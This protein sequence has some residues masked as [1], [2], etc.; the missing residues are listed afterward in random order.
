[1]LKAHNGRMMEYNYHDK[2]MLPDL[3]RQAVLD[4]VRRAD[5]YMQKNEVAERNVA[6]DFYYNR[7]IDV[8]LQQWFPGTTLNQVPP[9]G[10]R[11]VPRFAKSRMMVLKNI[12]RFV[13]GENAEEYL[14]FTHQLDS[15]A[16]EFSE[17]A[18]LLGRC[19][20]RSKW[21]DRK[22]RIEYDIIPH[23]KEY[24]DPDGYTF[25][26]SYEIHKDHKGKRQFVFWSETRE[27][28][29]GMHFIFNT[30]SEIKPVYGR[31]DIENPYGI[32]PVSKVEFPSNSMDIARGGLQISIAYTELA[33]AIRFALGQPVVTGI[34][35][36]IPNLKAGID[37]LISL[38]E[39]DFKYVS[40]TGSIRDMVEAIKVVCNQLAQN[41]DL[42]IRWGEG[43]TPP[44]GEALRIMSMGNLESRESDMPLFKEWEHNRYEIDR[45]LLLVH[46]N[47]NLNESYAV[48]FAEAEFPL[49]WSEKKDRYLFLLDQGLMTKKELYLKEVNPDALPEEIEE[50]FKE[51]QEEQV[52]EEPQ[53]NTP[54]LDI[55]QS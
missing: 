51:I 23:V 26:V 5:D 43:G 29:P 34:D 52:L 3:G 30:S 22:Q 9:F 39:G 25:G 6:L 37:R 18:W 50:K 48:D 41:H 11:I 13:G 55:L 7:N 16:R 28:N 14:S 24:C 40:P 1:M 8:H 54:L 42:A 38:S 32:I 4:S 12:E 20:F 44:S 19:Y 10:M 49:S 35:T 27:G 45:T 36:E 46:M 15:K 21:N 53:Q 2:I 31:E 17:V 33:L 47:K